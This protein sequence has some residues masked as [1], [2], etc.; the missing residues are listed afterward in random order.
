MTYNFMG[1]PMVQNHL[2]IPTFDEFFKKIETP[3]QIIELGT[4]QG[5]L[6]LFLHISCLLNSCHFI[7]YDIEG[8]SL[9]YSD[10][11]SKINIDA[12][13]KNIFE[14][15]EEIAQIIQSKGTTVL[16]C[17]N[18]NKI[19]E[20]N[21]FSRYLKSGDFI[22]AHDYSKDRDFF[23]REMSGKLWNHCEIIYADIEESVNLH[24]L[25][26]FM[27]EGWQRAAWACFQKK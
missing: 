16:L 4:E 3:S 26:P 7:T 15:E 12:R 17:D 13:N 8:S 20:F 11:F 9:K 10:V 18:G 14:N 23:M 1:V 5:G 19:R 25:I 27:E 24:G 2:A 22:F 6:S 21:T